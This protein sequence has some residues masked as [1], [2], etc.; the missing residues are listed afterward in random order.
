MAAFSSFHS[1]VPGAPSQ[2]ASG[3]STPRV[4]QGRVTNFA[5]TAR[6]VI[7]AAGEIALFLWTVLALAFSLLVMA[8]FFF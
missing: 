3:V 5:E 2:R 7:A 6:Q 8:G 4:T 1:F